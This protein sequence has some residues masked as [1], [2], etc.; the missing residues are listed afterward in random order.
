MGASGR[1]ERM[2]AIAE[3]VVG[4]RSAAAHRGVECEAG[5]VGQGAFRVTGTQK[6]Q[7]G[8]VSQY[9]ASHFQYK[10]LVL[11]PALNLLAGLN[12]LQVNGA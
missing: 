5:A 8:S 10:P 3:L 2:P 4:L 6:K 11:G 7:L 12:M 9:G 1:T